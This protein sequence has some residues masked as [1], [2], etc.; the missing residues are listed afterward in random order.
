ML[1]FIYLTLFLIGTAVGSFLNVLINRSIGGESWVTGRSRCDHCGKP[2]RWFDLVPVFSYLVYRGKSRCCR[3][4]LSLQHPVVEILTGM[5][6]VWWMAIGS[7]FFQL[8]THPLPL[9]QYGYWLIIGV[10]LL[11]ILAMDLFYGLIPIFFVSAGIV[12]TLIYRLALILSGV[13]KAN[14]LGLAVISAAG[15]WLFFRFLR[16]ITK[17]KGMGEGDEYLAI[18]V[19]LVLGWPRVLVG[20]MGSFILGAFIATPLVLF[21]SKNLKSSVPFGPFMIAATAIALVFGQKILQMIWG[22]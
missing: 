10:I 7:A 11:I 17:G 13:Y 2:L 8:V 9:V 12:I 4:E 18:L 3:K 15:A 5:L 14:D 1:W 19:G 21:G 20:I 6:F 16:A 22:I